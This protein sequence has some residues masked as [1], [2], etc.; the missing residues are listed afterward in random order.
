MY[1]QPSLE[2][3][4]IINNERLQLYLMKDIHFVDKKMQV[5]IHF[6]LTPPL[7]FQYNPQLI[8]VYST[9]I[10]LVICITAEWISVVIDALHQLSLVNYFRTC[11]ILWKFSHVCQFLSFVA[12]HRVETVY[13][14]YYYRHK[15][16]NIIL[17][18]HKS[19][20]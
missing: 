20:R 7:M 6:H 15:F 16:R 18:L 17:N 3:R 2:W 11:T 13:T 4:L 8:T 14:F 1:G 19:R 10:M 12:K 9:T 5:M